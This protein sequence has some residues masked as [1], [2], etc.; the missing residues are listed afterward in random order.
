M[1]KKYTVELQ[2][3]EGDIL[4]IP[5]ELMKELGWKIGDKIKFKDLGDGSF[6]ITK[7]EDSQ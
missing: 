1:N 3:E 7:V 2:G 5:E 6:S 4:P